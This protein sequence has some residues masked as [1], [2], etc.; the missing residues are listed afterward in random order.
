MLV[1]FAKFKRMAINC[2]HGFLSV[3]VCVF[4]CL[5][6]EVKQSCLHGPMTTEHESAQ[7]TDAKSI[8]QVFCSIV[9][10]LGTYFVRGRCQGCAFS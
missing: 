4:V 1:P 8:A 7:S 6:A 5:F 3:C 9:E 2:L 10:P